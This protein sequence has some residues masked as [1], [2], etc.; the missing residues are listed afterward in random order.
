LQVQKYLKIGIGEGV[1]IFLSRQQVSK[2]V[3]NKIVVKKNPFRQ[4]T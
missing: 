4:N 1:E 2:T 3:F